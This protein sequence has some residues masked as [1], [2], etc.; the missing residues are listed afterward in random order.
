MLR[1]QD[2]VVSASTGDPNSIYMNGRIKHQDKE[3]KQVGMRFASYVK[4]ITSTGKISV[5]KAGVM[6]V[7]DAGELVLFISAG[8]SY[9]GKNAEETARRI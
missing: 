4:G 2:A 3:G 6:T 8:T 7:K 1:E 9:G 5:N